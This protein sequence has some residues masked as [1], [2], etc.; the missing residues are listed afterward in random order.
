MS[1]GV[2]MTRISGI[3]CFLLVALRLVI[4]WHFAVEGVHKLR[5]HQIGKT[6][7]N[8]PWTSEPFFREG[9]GPAAEWY[10]QMLGI[11][12]EPTLA[13]FRIDTNRNG[14]PTESEW[15]DYFGRFPGH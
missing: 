1:A 12:D 8:T 11:T 7:T 5:T 2:S 6:S 4:G 15:I 10:R 14:F 3:A 13:R 9:Y